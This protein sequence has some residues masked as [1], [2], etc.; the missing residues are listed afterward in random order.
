MPGTVQYCVV[1][2]LYQ[3]MA[4]QGRHGQG[5]APENCMALRPRGLACGHWQYFLVCLPEA[6]DVASQNCADAEDEPM[7]TNAALYA[8][9]FFA[10]TQTT[11]ALIRAGKWYAIALETLAEEVQ[12]LGARDHRE[13]RR[14]LQR[15]VTHLLKSQYQP[16][17]RQTGHIWRSTIQTQ[18]QEIADLLEQSPSLRRTVPD[19][20]N[21]RYALAR[22]HASAQ[23]RLSLVTFPETCPWT[24]E[25]VLDA[26]FWPEG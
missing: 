7:S 15:L 6:D 23:T 22:E 1:R 2:V 18:R 16:S 10:W 5:T 13:L 19:A 20:I 9:D 12:S 8:Q 17:R 25:Q 4:E 21:T 26:G 3:S 14:R 24:A 11:A